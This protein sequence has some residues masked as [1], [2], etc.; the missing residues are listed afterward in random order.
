MMISLFKNFQRPNDKY[1][2]FICK[3]GNGLE[4]TNRFDDD[5]KLV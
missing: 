2:N 5:A 3:R 1:G 4:L